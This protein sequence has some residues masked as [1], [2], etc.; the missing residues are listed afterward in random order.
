MPL[1]DVVLL[2][3][4]WVD[5]DVEMLVAYAR[6]AGLEH[7]IHFKAGMFGSGLVTLSRWGGLGWRLHNLCVFASF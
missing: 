2:Q 4:V 5:S 1:Q 6:T 3:E 7:A